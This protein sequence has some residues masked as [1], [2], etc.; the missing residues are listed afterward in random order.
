MHGAGMGDGDQHTPFNLPTSLV[1]GGGGQLAGNRNLVY[2]LHTPIM[3][4]GLT[5]LEKVGVQVDRIADST[6]PLA[7]V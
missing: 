4:L 2:Q 7:G 6:G 3:N 5:L 1:G